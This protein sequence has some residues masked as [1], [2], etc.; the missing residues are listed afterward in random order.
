MISWRRKKHRITQHWGRIRQCFAGSLCHNE[1]LPSSLPAPKSTLVAMQIR[2]WAQL[3]L[4]HARVEDFHPA[5]SPSCSW[6]LCRDL[7]HR[8]WSLYEVCGLLWQQGYLEGP[9]LIWS[10]FQ[11]GGLQAQSHGYGRVQVFRTYV[12]LDSLRQ[13][14]ATSN[15]EV[16]LDPK[17]KRRE[18]KGQNGSETVRTYKIMESVP[19]EMSL[20]ILLGKMKD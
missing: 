15:K 10:P 12:D 14:I 9:S 2:Q 1:R 13:G 19:V 18:R 20:D 3:L 16:M 7:L 4:L 8:T 11:N 5:N 17:Q 6:G